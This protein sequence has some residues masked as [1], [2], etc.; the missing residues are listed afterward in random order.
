MNNELRTV[1][2]KFTD[3]RSNAKK[4]TIEFKLTFDEWWDIW[5]SSGHWENRGYGAGKYCMS[6]FNDQGPYEVGNVFVQ[7]HTDNSIQGHLGLKMSDETK[8]KMSL[9]H[10]ER[11]S[12]M[13]GKKRSPEFSA[14]I[15]AT[16]A[17]KKELSDVR[18]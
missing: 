2:K 18:V 16:W 14:K 6:R 7:L 12:P 8:L 17:M 13:K 4:R 5:Q 9:A 15:K 3:H 10:S 11:I 1:R